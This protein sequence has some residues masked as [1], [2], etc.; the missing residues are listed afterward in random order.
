MTHD[1]MRTTEHGNHQSLSVFELAQF[2]VA[3]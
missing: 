1:L 3:S 2:L